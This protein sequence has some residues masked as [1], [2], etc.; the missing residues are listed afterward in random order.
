VGIIL[1][2]ISAQI[3]GTVASYLLGLGRLG[4]KWHFGIGFAGLM[5]GWVFVTI[6]RT[7][8]RRR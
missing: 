7:R 1:A 5:L 6:L 8:H 2:L 4:P 3:L